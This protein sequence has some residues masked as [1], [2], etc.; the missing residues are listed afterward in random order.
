M[1]RHKRDGSAS[2]FGRGERPQVA[3]TPE[4]S[5]L[6]AA[7][8][9]VAIGVSGGKDSSAVAFATVAY[10]DSIGHT[11]PRILIHSDLGVT[12]WEQSLEWC[13]RLAARL[14]LEL[15]V[16]RRPKGDMMQRWE[17][18][19][20]D[21]VA[22][23]RALECVQLI[24]PWSTPDMRFCTSEMKVDVICRELSRRY[25][26]QTIVNVNGIRREESTARAC[27][28]VWKEQPKLTSKTLATLGVDWHPI[29][30][31]TLEDVLDLL[32]AVDFPLHPAYLVWM[33]TRVS[34]VFCIMSSRDDLKNAARCP[35]NH[36]IYRRMVNLELISTFAFQGGNWLADVAP[37]ILAPGQRK[38]VEAVKAKAGR[39]QDLEAWIPK[40]LLYVKGW[41]VTIPTKSAA[42]ELCRV[43]RGMSELFELDCQFLD[44][45]S[46]IGRYEELWLE[47]WK[48]SE[49]KAK[50]KSRKSQK[51]NHGQAG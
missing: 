9:P 26:G 49:K 7:N 12:E 34:C 48:R 20:S 19:W 5:G 8:A 38:V 13:Q 47:N 39:R 33:L 4:I 11:G 45:E 46:L 6:L 43:R 27:K 25:P 14:G 31:W 41:P 16:V 21:N 18:R 36:D 2:L 15:I 10:L 51:A 28:P 32:K 29:I 23:Y 22:R 50:A 35:A 42:V 1:R 30:E 37:E 24:L 44:P 3:V 40:D 17:Q